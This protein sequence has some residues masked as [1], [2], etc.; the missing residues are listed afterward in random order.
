V[1]IDELI[2]WH[3]DRHDAAQ[4][5]FARASTNTTARANLGT[6]K[7]HAETVEHLERLREIISAAGQSQ[8]AN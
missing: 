2:S 4:K 3:K 6:A 5:R 7:A 8:G 1:T